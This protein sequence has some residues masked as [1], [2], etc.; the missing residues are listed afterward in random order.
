MQWSKVIYIQFQENTLRVTFS[1][2]ILDWIKILTVEQ[3]RYLSITVKKN[4]DIDIKR[5]TR[6]LYINV[7]LLMRKFSTCSVSVK[8]MLFKTYCSNIYCALMWFDCTKAA[9][10]K[11]KIALKLQSAT[12]YVLTMA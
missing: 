9:L 12:I 3:F 5:H 2:L 11:L 10:K 4:S 6:K 8:S 1:V 7:N